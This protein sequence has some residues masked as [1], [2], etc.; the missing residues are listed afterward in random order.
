MDCSNS[1]CLY[2][3]LRSA[4]GVFEQDQLEALSKMEMLVQNFYFRGKASPFPFERGVLAQIRCL[5]EL[6]KSLD[7]G[8]SPLLTC[9]LNQ[10]C[11]ENLFSCLRGTGAGPH[12]H[13]DQLEAMQRAKIRLLCTDYRDHI[14]PIEKPRKAVGNFKKYSLYTNFL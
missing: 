14:I 13:P 8:C 2:D 11:V 10:D 1:R 12:D 5:R 6:Y 3:G 4:F 9:R 7:G